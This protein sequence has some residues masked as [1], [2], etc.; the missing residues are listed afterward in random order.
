MK[1]QK[2]LLEQWVNSVA[3]LQKREVKVDI[4]S[5]RHWHVLNDCGA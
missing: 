4:T 3:H 2:F 5:C 1:T